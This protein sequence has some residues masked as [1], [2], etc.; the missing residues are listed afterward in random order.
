MSDTWSSTADFMVDAQI[1]HRKP[2]KK[3]LALA[4]RN[5]VKYYSHGEVA[6]WSKAVAC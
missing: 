4:E 5:V 3:S 6:E 1:L 2:H